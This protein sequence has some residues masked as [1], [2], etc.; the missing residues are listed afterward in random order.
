M[1]QIEQTCQQNKPPNTLCVCGVGGCVDTHVCKKMWRSEGWHQCLPLFSKTG[2]LPEQSTPNVLNDWSARSWDPPT[3]LVLGLQMYPAFLWLLGTISSWWCRQ[4]VDLIISPSQQWLLN[5]H[6][7]KIC[8]E[9]KNY[10]KKYSV[11]HPANICL[12]KEL[13]SRWRTGLDACSEPTCHS[14]NKAWQHKRKQ[15]KSLRCVHLERSFTT[16][17]KEIKDIARSSCSAT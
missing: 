10:W 11:P 4:S 16:E 6:N 13:K 2:P 15:G 3:M 7:V 8:K 5:R 12:Y 17:Q 14:V 9:G 1:R